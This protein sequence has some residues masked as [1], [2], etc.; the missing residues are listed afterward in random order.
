MPK[1]KRAEDSLDERL[2]QFK[3]DL[4]RALKRV[5]GFERQRLSRRLHEKGL[6]EEKKQK[7]D[8]EVAVLKVRKLETVNRHIDGSQLVSYGPGKQTN[9]LA[10]LLSRWTSIKPRSTTSTPLYSE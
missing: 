1:R 2:P 3:T 9:F 7:Y 6:S 5:K 10:A 8:L 4:F